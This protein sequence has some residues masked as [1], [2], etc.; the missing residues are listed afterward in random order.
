MRK[1]LDQVFEEL[2]FAVAGH[3]KVSGRTLFA[4]YNR[5]GR[6]MPRPMRVVFH[7]LAEAEARHHAGDRIAMVPVVEASDQFLG[8]LSQF[9]PNPAIWQAV[10]RNV[11]WNM[12]VFLI[13]LAGCAILYNPI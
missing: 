13:A 9:D 6:Q 11:I 12:G 10:K 3:F 1:R 4:Q 7:Q 8:Q 2:R 5:I